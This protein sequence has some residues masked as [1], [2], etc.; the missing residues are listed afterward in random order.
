[1]QKRTICRLFD[2][3]RRAEG[4]IKELAL[5]QIPADDLR[6]VPARLERRSFVQ[7]AALVYAHVDEADAAR[8]EATLMRNGGI[9]VEPPRETQSG[10][11]N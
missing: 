8:V 5:T 9:D 11:P 10:R 7:D 1:M 6:L 4:T 3:P 2:D